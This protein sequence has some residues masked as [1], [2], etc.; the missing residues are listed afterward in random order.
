MAKWYTGARDLGLQYEG[1]HVD[2]TRLP[3]V[4]S[5]PEVHRSE[6]EGKVRESLWWGNTSQSPASAYS[7]TESK[8]PSRVI[9][10]CYEALELPGTS[11]DYHFVVL[12]ALASAWSER[13]RQP[14]LYEEV[15]KLAL[16]DIQIIER[17]PS[18]DPEMDLR[19]VSQPAFDRLV[20]LYRGEGYL[21]DAI[22]IADRASRFLGPHVSDSRDQA[23][24]W[25][26]LATELRD[27]TSQLP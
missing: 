2:R 14:D 19:T 20:E 17:G 6:F 9:Q 12:G 22:I 11:S 18:D 13:R 23:S 15:E 3:G 21:E 25:E 1:P 4:N 16:L 7:S 27:I 8:N 5:R 10:R 26:A 24:E